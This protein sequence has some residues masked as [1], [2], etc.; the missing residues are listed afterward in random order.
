MNANPD[1]RP[2]AIEL[3]E[4]IDFWDQKYKLS[5][6]KKNLVIKEK[7]LNLCLKKLIKKYKIFQL[8]M[9]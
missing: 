5:K 6:K 1:Q 4:I 9:R 7:R 8:H 2:T 3:Y